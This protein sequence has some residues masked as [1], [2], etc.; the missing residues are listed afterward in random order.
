MSSCT[1][2]CSCARRGMLKE[3]NL[4]PRV[5]PQLQSEGALV[6]ELR[7]CR[8]SII[9][10]LDGYRDESSLAAQ[11]YYRVEGVGEYLRNSR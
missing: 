3:E 2:E 9:T 11:N 4:G 8:Y 10:A 7:W 1:A 5:C 6:S